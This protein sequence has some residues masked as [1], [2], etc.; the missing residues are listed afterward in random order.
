LAGADLDG[1]TFPQFHSNLKYFTRVILTCEFYPGNILLCDS[2]Y[3]EAGTR[4]ENLMTKVTEYS[5]FAGDRLIVSGNLETTVLRTKAYLARGEAD[6][7]LIFDNQNGQEIDFDFR[8]TSEEVLGRLSSH[9]LVAKAEPVTAQR[10]GPGRP[11]LGVVSREVSLL[12]RHWEWLEQQSGGMSVALRKL[13]EE[14][15]KAGQ[16]KQLAQRARDVAGKFMWVMAGNLPN[17]EEAS[18]ALYADNPDRLREL[19]RDWPADIRNHL[20]RLVLELTRL[21][22]EANEEKNACSPL[23]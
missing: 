18:R 16:G 20:E 7:V 9:P 15:R 23:S 3:S 14:A 10:K 12:P 17:F 1:L 8:G 6:T 21:N 4:M 11:K 13:V 2:A 5:V 22:R 19:I